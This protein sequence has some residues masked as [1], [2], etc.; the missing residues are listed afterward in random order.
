[1]AAHKREA[2]ASHIIM[3][4]FGWVFVGIFIAWLL[5]KIFGWGQYCE[6]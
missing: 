5:S 4:P 3:K 2:L 6:C 1:M